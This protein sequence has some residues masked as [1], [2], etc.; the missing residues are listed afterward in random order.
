M[1]REPEQAPGVTRALRDGQLDR[2]TALWCDGA[3]VDWQAMHPAGERRTVQL[4]AHPF[5]RD[6]YWVPAGDGAP[7]PP[8]A[9]PAPPPAAEPAFETDARAELLRAVLDGR[10]DP[11]ALSRT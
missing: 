2:V 1:R 9:A 6:R 3:P 11:D 10:A 5:A 8:P 4:P 7:V